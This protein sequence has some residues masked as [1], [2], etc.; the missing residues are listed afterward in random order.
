MARIS[1]GKG[2]KQDYGSPEVLM[3]QIKKHFP[4]AWDLAAN[5]GNTKAKLWC[6][7][8]GA[9]E[10]AFEYDW[11]MLSVKSGE[12]LWL[13]PPYGNIGPWYLNCQRM[14]VRGARI[15]SLVPMDAARW[16]DYVPGYAGIWHLQGRVKFDGAKDSNTKDS[17]LHIWAP[18]YAN[19]YKIWNWKEDRFLI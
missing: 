2:S 1:T 6:G 10:D 18:E 15:L 14:Q 11:S 16:L 8:G 17:A 12:W 13:N 5:K 3:T 7:P 19:T 9:F 4:I